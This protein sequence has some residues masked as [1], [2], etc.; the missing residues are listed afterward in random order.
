MKYVNGRMLREKEN[1]GRRYIGYFEKLMSVEN[2][3]DAC[4][5]IVILRERRSYKN[6]C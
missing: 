5:D 2:Q 4:L 3:G 6:N 1:I